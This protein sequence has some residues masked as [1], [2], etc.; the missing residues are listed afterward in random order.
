[1]KRVDIATSALP[2]ADICSI[3]GAVRA[4]ERVYLSG[5]N[6]LQPDGR[7]LGVGDATA[8]THAALDRLEL[9]LKAA[10]G[11][12]ANITKLTTCIVD[13][14]YRAQ[15]YSVIAERLKNVYPVSTGLV[16]AGLGLPELIVQIDAEA[17]IP[18]KPVKKTR[19][20]SLDNWHG[21]GF[22]WQGSMVIATDDE[23]FVRGQTGASL[24]HSGATSAGRGLK[25]AEIQADLALK[26]LA[27]LLGESGSSMEDVCKITVYISDRAYRPVVYP[28]IGKHFGTV[29]PVSTGIVISALARPEILFEIDV[30]VLRKKNDKPHKRVRP[31]WH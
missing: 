11:S 5:A 18:T 4:G 24:D 21:Q 20:Y 16:V 7:V 19:P 15:I 13:R 22:A 2:G 14:G 23:L 3:A 9:S 17:A 26:N 1:M 30:N 25:D 31:Q 28:M 10:G 29:R 8:Q 27:Q 12:L 6:A